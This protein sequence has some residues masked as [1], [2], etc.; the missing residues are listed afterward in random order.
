MILCYRSFEPSILPTVLFIYLFAFVGKSI[1]YIISIYHK[2][3][4]DGNE[5]GVVN[6]H[7]CSHYS[8]TESWLLNYWLQWNNSKKS[9]RKCE[10]CLQITNNRNHNF[11]DYTV[12]RCIQYSYTTKINGKETGEWSWDEKTN[13]GRYLLQNV[14]KTQVYTTV[15]HWQK[16]VFEKPTN[17]KKQIIINIIDRKDA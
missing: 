14:G 6:H 17:T 1:L 13:H 7:R 11:L 4:K 2:I 12:N 16:L 15:L 3:S 10:V 9:S 8:N 5:R